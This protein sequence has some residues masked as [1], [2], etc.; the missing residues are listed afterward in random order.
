[1]IIRKVMLQRIGKKKEGRKEIYLPFRWCVARVETWKRLKMCVE[2]T[3]KMM[4]A[5]EQQG[6]LCIVTSGSIS[7]TIPT[8]TSTSRL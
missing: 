7:I 1:M 3:M 4:D 5:G 6:R 8:S 2:W